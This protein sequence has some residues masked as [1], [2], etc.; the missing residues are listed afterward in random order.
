MDD[1]PGPAGLVVPEPTSLSRAASLPGP[2]PQLQLQQ[3][4]QQGQQQQ[5]AG[6]GAGAV[7]DTWQRTAVAA[8]AAWQLPVSGQPGNP[9]AALLPLTLPSSSPGLA[10]LSS[11]PVS[12]GGGDDDGFDDWAL[13]QE[14]MQ[15]VTANSHQLSLPDAFPGFG[16]PAAGGAG[17]AGGG[18]AGGDIL[19]GH[20]HLQQQQQQQS[21]GFGTAHQAQQQQQ[22]LLAPVSAAESFISAALEE[23]KCSSGAA[24]G[25]GGGTRHLLLECPDISLLANT[26]TMV[27]AWIRQHVGR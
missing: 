10:G 26:P 7:E 21:P 13:L 25:L 15:A 24:A 20:A 6:A 11:D 2:S 1:P 18:G 17:A 14:A 5:A 19:G 23:M 16:G 12:I 8:A 3:G 22:Q 9:V 4:Q 27:E